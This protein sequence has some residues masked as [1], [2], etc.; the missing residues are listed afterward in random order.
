MDEEVLSC[1]QIEKLFVNSS[2]HRTFRHQTHTQARPVV[3]VTGSN[4]YLAKEQDPYN[5]KKVFK[6]TVVAQTGL[7]GTSDALSGIRNIPI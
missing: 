6:M 5:N 7:T 4:R 2:Y 1:Q 3:H